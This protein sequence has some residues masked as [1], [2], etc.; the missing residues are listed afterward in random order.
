MSRTYEEVTKELDKNIPAESVKERSNGNFTLSYLEGHY[1]IDRLNK[2]LGIGNWAYGITKM[3][4]V[5]SGSVKD[6]YDK[7]IYYASYVT[8]IRLVVTLPDGIQTEFSDVGFGDGQDK[9]NPGKP[10]ELAT[11]E[12][13]TDALKR[14]AKNL[15][16]SMGLALYNKER[17]NVD[18][19]IIETPKAKIAPIPTDDLQRELNLI[20]SA[21]KVLVKQGH[22]TV[23]TL[24]AEMTKRY[25][26]A[27]KEKLT[28][29]QAK[30]F[31]NH[32]LELTK[33]QKGATQ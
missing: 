23:D 4:C 13:V 26:V 14:C 20:S 17:T 28:H 11:K 24:R 31:K 10:H 18:D 22:N 33:T 8:T 2:V 5:F 29:E 25:G 7:E 15:G 9:S 19:K 21:S 6:K 1:V 30:D 16:Q 27:E 3:D 32:L 12:A